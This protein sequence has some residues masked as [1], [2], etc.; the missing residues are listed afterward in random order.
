M[1]NIRGI[2]YKKKTPLPSLR[3]QDWGTVKSETVKV[4]DIDKYLDERHYG[5]KRFNIRGPL[6]DHRYNVKTW[7]GTQT[8]ITDKNDYDHKQEF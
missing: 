4:N 6:E 7:V 5:V 8:W 3:N 1:D 2:T